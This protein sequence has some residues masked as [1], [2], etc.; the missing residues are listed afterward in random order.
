[1]TAAAVMTVMIVVGTGTTGA[2]P[3][4]TQANDRCTIVG[5]SGDDALQG[6][7]SRDVICGLAGDD[8]IR[9]LGGDDVVLGGPGN[10]TIDGGT[11]RDSLDGSTGDDRLRGASGDDLL[12]G[13]SGDDRLAGSAGVDVL[14]AGSGR[15]VCQAGDRVVGSCTVDRSGP[16][17]EAFTAPD[18]V[19]AGST[20]TFTW[21]LSDPA[22]VENAGVTIGWS[23]GL[24]TGCGFA[25]SGTRVSGTAT[26]GQW[27]YTCT[28]PANAVATEYSAQVIAADQ[29]GNVSLSEWATFRIDGPNTDATPPTYG[30][31]RTLGT[32][33]IG[34]ELTITWTVSDAGGV[35]GAI[36]WVA[37]PGGGFADTTGRPFADYSTPVRQQCTADRTS[38]TMTQTTRLAA[39]APPGTWALWISAT[40]VNAN[41][42]LEPA[43][44][45]TVLGA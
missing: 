11:G 15:N 1:M 38:C 16:T 21:R 37:G 5:T 22:G 26:D 35:D 18:V 45:L 7:S 6:T 24:Y 20:I 4:V 25:Q 42:V 12:V 30:D 8:R 32:V 34:E 27:Q 10:D 41:K 19:T 2:Q 17:V 9:G 33:R 39:T 31:I 36:M 29:F 28:L 13:G 44:T 14:A 40:D 23:P 3:P 43:L